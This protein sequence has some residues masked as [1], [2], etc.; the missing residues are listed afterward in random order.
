M[1]E[2]Y[3]VGDQT[4]DIN[5]ID[6]DGILIS[7]HENGSGIAIRSNPHDVDDEVAIC[8]NL[9]VASDNVVFDIT[10]LDR[11]DSGSRQQEAV[12]VYGTLGAD[13]TPIM[14]TITPLT[15]A[16]CIDKVTILY[17]T[18]SDSPASN[19]D[20]GKITIGENLGFTS[21]VCDNPCVSSGSGREDQSN[22]DI[23]L[24]PNPVYGS[25]SVTIEIDTE[26]RGAAQIVLI[27]ALGRTVTSTNIELVNKITTHE[28]STRQLASGIYF[29]QLQTNEWRTGGMKLVV[30]KP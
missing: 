26:A 15:F 4:Y 29:V 7:T 21:T 9:S 27:D 6:G 23:N 10:D 14:P 1:M 2:S 25:N 5:I 17:G 20:E 22:A 28:I 12:C 8:Y 24:Y 3:D 11:K 19:P 16:E 30:A 18:G 13:P